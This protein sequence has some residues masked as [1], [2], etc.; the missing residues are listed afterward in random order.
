M[1]LLFVVIVSRFITKLCFQQSESHRMNLGNTF[2]SNVYIRFQGIDIFCNQQEQL[3]SGYDYTFVCVLQDII[4]VVLKITCELQKLSFDNNDS[5]K[6]CLQ[7][8]V[9]ENVCEDRKCP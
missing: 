4:Q 6:Y 2:Q 1:T 3:C 5:L 7:Q 8:I 9:A